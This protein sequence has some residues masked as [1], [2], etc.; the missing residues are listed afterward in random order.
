MRKKDLKVCSN[1]FPQ[2]KR[3]HW[4]SAFKCVNGG[5]QGSMA[6]SPLHSTHSL[7]N[8]TMWNSIHASVIELVASFYKQWMKG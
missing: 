8:V 2:E 7:K 4:E 1:K 6:D 5:T 3:K